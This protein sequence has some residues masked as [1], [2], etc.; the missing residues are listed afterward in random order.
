MPPAESDL[1]DRL[2]EALAAHRDGRTEQAETGYRT[3]LATQP[4]QPMARHLLGVLLLG[5][6]RAALALPHLRRAAALRPHHAETRFA[7]ANACATTGALAEAIGR[8]QALLA[9]APGHVGAQ[10]NLANALRDAGDADGAIATC[11]VALATAPDLI[12]AQLTLGSALLLA[13]Q[14]EAAATAYHAAVTRQPDCAPGWA[15]LGMAH[16]HLDQPAA[17]LAAAGRAAAL[18]PTL[19]EAHF[20]LGLAQSALGQPATAALARCL[21]LVPGH[22]RAHLALGNALIDRDDMAAAEAELRRAIALD[23]TVPEAHAS[24]GFL[25]S[26]T[27][28]LSEAVAACDAAIA[29]RPDFARAHW[30]KSVAQLLAGNF[31]EGWENYEWRKRH[32]RFARDFFTLPGREWQGETLEGH[33]LLVHAEQGLGDTLQFVRYVPLLAARGARVVLACA[34]PLI[35]LLAGMPGLAAIAAR[36]APLPHYD[37]W[38]DQMSLPRLFGTRPET[39]PAPHGYLMADPA[40][41]AAWRA[42][43]GQPPG[44]PRIGIVWSGNPAHHNDRRRSLPTAALA[45]LL[46]Q[47]CAWISLQKGPRAAEIAPRH[48][49]ADLS[50]RLHDFA[51]T[52]ALIATLDLV[53]AVD[54]SVAHLAGALGRPVWVMLPHA[55]D[56]RWM[57]GRD[58]SPWYAT[59]RLFR[60]DRPGDWAGVLARV[61]GALADQIGARCSTSIGDRPTSCS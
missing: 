12:A 11:R 21:A 5:T 46:A 53:I 56:W 10:V 51:E 48:G 1:I 22:A 45:P 44:Q 26:A 19:A 50:P 2:A 52:A 58:D 28:R 36:D 24:L 9:D 57:T 14:A 59:M 34:A 13:G 32:D 60:Q 7:L 6:G 43:S 20:V 31:A 41:V 33:T 30:N 38:V 47:P 18:A 61:A 55:P 25:L 15:G 42:E 35:P 49:I 23:P 16:M 8:Y 4:D 29:L 39:I 17:A 27:A 3:V 37:L 54:T 40:R